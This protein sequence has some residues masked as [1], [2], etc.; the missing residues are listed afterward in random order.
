MEVSMQ[1]DIHLNYLA[2]LA[3]V[4]AYVAIGSMWYGPLFGKACR[5]TKAD[6]KGVTSCDMT[7]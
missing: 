4:V 3:A 1:P 6:N 5:R 2:I 7:F